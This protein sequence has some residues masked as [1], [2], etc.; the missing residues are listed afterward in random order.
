VIVYGSGSA[1]QHQ[2]FTVDLS[3]GGF[4]LAGPDTLEI[5][6]DITFRIT[7]TP[8]ALPI[9]GVGRVVRV[10]KHGRRAVTFQ[11]IS[12]LDRR[13]VVRFLFELRRNERQRG[14][15]GDKHGG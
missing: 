4:L 7:L 13:R 6:E 12:D 8:E 10:D 14:V 11:K 2:S 5:G 3:G 1:G 9:T 15:N